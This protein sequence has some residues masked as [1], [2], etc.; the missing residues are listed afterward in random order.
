MSVDDRAP[1]AG[2]SCWLGCADAANGSID[3]P[4]ASSDA[5]VIGGNR[6]AERLGR[7]SDLQSC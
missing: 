6:K 2:A 1:N 4:P 5:C 3:F 7:A